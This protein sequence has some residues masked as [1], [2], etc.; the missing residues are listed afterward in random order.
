[1]NERRTTSPGRKGPG[2]LGCALLLGESAER[3]DW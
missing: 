1:M 2:S 3:L